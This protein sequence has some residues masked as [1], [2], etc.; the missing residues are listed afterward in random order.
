MH[1][2]TEIKKMNEPE[3]VPA[4]CLS[5]ANVITRYT[6]GYSAYLEETNVAGMTACDCL[7]IAV[8][9]IQTLIARIAELEAK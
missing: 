3:Y 6:D 2:L 5:A 9:D 4:P 7:A 1:G 8:E